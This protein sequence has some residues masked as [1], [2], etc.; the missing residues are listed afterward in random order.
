MVN[1]KIPRGRPRLGCAIKIFRITFSLHVGEDDVLIEIFEGIPK[2][3]RALFLKMLILSGGI[4]QT[5]STNDLVED[6]DETVDEL[7]F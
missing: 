5:G 2:R 7:V 4:K 6:I 3:R 1:N